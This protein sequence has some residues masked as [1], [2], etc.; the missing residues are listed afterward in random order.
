MIT[1]NEIGVLKQLPSCSDTQG[2][3]PGGGAA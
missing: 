3:I 1:P 2:G